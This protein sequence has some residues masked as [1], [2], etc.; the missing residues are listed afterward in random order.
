[1]SKTDDP[2]T[3]C[4]TPAEGRDGVTRI[5]SWKYE[6]LRGAIIEV[7]DEAGSDG[8]AFSNLTE[9]VRPRLSADQLDRL[10]SLGWHVTTV[11]LNMEVEGDIAR[12]PGSPQR[13]V[14]VK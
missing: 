9:A 11:K 1:M 13:L 4:R 8:L 2:K 12:L 3:E 6:C 10:G 14:V 7:V 5:P